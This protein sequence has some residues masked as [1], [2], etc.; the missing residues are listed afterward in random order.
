MSELGTPEL[1][2]PGENAESNAVGLD[3]NTLL[4]QDIPTEIHVKA[5]EYAEA[6]DQVDRWKDVAAEKLEHLAEE[7]EQNKNVKLFT[8]RT[9][10]GVRIIWVEQLRKI[11]NKKA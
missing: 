8:V 9:E 10:M 11:R 6:L 1:P 3:G 2:M 5:R 4:E 7:L